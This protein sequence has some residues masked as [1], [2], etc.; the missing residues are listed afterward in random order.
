MVPDQ[1][2]ERHL[3][4]VLNEALQ[5]HRVAQLGSMLCAGQPVQVVKDA[6]ELGTE[7]GIRSPE[8]P[9]SK[10]IGTGGGCTFFVFSSPFTGR[11]A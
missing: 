8:V 4:T 3:V 11:H 1:S 10:V 2:L 9:H 6:A 5:Q 7:H